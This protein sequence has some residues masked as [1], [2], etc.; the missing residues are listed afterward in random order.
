VKSVCVFCGSSFGNNAQYRT[1]AEGLG[2][3]LAERG[4]RLIYGG[5]SL[6]LMGALAD[7]SLSGGGRVVGVIPEAMAVREVAHTGLSEL[8]VTPSMH[9]R[10][11]L[12]AELADAFVALP[13]GLGTCDE[14]FEIVTWAQLGIHRKPIGLLNVAGYF[15]ALIRL[16]EHAVTEGFV[17][18]QHL[19]LLLVGEVAEEL[20]ERLTRFEPGPNVPKWI[21]PELA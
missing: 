9:A 7:A 14:L 13:G 1:A 10:K 18:P 16:V 15:D 12:M 3:L 6:G 11:A 5:G 19:E 17:R 4:L 2:R 20:L 21:R 8:R